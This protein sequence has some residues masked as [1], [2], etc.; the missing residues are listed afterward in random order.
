M[1][2]ISIRLWMCS[3]WICSK[4][5]SKKRLDN[6]QYQALRIYSGAIRTTP[7]S[8]LQVEMGEMSTVIIELLG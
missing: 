1:N 7:T 5:I 6:I 2:Q 4:H 3:V 8:A